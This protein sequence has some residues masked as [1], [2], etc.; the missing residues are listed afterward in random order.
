MKHGVKNKI[1]QLRF[2]KI[3]GFSSNLRNG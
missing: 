3:C 1:D 2:I